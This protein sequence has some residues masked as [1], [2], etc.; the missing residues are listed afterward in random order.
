MKNLLSLSLLVLLFSANAS[1]QIVTSKKE[2]IKKGI[3]SYNEKS[4]TE[5]VAFTGK[6]SASLGGGVA[7]AAQPSVLSAAMKTVS[8]PSVSKPDNTAKP[9]AGTTK[10]EEPKTK[11]LILNDAPEDPDFI[12]ST[13]SYFAEQIVNNALNFVGVHYRGGGTS[14]DG[15]DCSGMVFAT[16]KIFDV[17]L[18][19]SSQAMSQIGEEVKLSEVKKGDLL[20]F[21]NGHNRRAINHVGIVSDV[22]P[23]GEVLFVHSSTSSG[24][25]VSSMNEAYHSRTFVQAKRVIE[26]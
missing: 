9:K 1:A 4:A 16:F 6:K 7:S 22:T 14:R 25:T 23:E 11:R 18:P 26:E 2:A 21:K 3:Y 10:A 15:M 12:P 20:F 8:E 5:S 13:D 24:V 19:R 17:T